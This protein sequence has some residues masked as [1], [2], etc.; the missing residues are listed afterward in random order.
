MTPTEDE[1]K[2]Q[3]LALEARVRRLEALL[4]PPAR[5]IILAIVSGVTLIGSGIALRQPLLLPALRR[6]ALP[7]GRRPGGRVT[8][9]KN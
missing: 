7:Q 3:V 5:Q 9:R 8:W 6:L 2:R 4:P 1:L